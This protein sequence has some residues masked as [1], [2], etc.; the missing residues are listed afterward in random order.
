VYERASGRCAFRDA[1]GRRC[2]ARSR[3]EFHHR[4]PHGHGGDR[5]TDNISLLCKPHNRQL[6]EIDCGLAAIARHGRASG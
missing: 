4:H 1:S 6:A 5:S 2:E 3:L